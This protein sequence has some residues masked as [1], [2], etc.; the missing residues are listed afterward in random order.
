MKVVFWGPNRGKG[1]TTSCLLSIATNL[2]FNSHLKNCII[3]TDC[4]DRI[5][6][7]FI[8]KES[9]EVLLNSASGFGVNALLRDAKGDML[10][11][12]NIDDAALELSK[13]L[14]LYISASDKEPKSVEKSMQSS[15]TELLDALNRHYNIVFIDTKGG[16]TGFNTDVLASADL[17]VVCFAQD[18]AAIEDAFEQCNFTKNQCMFVMGNYDSNISC[19]LQ[20]LRN[21]H[22]EVSA[23]NSAKIIH[24]AEFA[25][26]RNRN[27][28]FKWVSTIQ[29]CKPKN[30]AYSYQKSVLEATSTMLKLL[31]IGGKE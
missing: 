24:C 3:S 9:E 14:S 4:K 28:L 11:E 6:S 26:A 10:T 29:G 5:Q 25:D 27:A 2:A 15:W 21:G 22:R 1:A 31:K 20:N 18:T 12:T 30:A 8:S 19:S 17:I 13:K 16:Y 23:A 7:N